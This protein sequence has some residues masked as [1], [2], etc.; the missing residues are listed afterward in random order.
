[1]L[2]RIFNASH[3][4]LVDHVACDTNHKQVPQPLRSCEKMR[5]MFVLN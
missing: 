5:N 2:D 1:M 3:R 4:F